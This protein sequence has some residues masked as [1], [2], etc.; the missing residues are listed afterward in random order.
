MEELFDPNTLLFFDED[1]EEEKAA[2][3]KSARERGDDQNDDDDDD[4]T[5]G[6]RGA[7]QRPVVAVGVTDILKLHPQTADDLQANMCA[8]HQILALIDTKMT[9]EK[10]EKLGKDVDFQHATLFMRSL[11]M[12]PLYKRRQMTLQ[13]I[14]RS[15][16]DKGLKNVIGDKKITC[17]NGQRFRLITLVCLRIDTDT[18]VV[19][20]ILLQ[21]PEPSP[22]AQQQQGAVAAATGPPV[23][24]SA[25]AAEEEIIKS[26]DSTPND[27]VF[28]LHILRNF[29]FDIQIVSID[30]EN[31]TLIY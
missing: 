9:P 10:R 14:V 16:M 15:V 2:K 6:G 7:A 29:Y 23:E 13:F 8:S 3:E 1:G 19:G 31:A 22:P 27:G 11:L 28:K 18:C 17:T 12:L 21:D 5:N 26:T 24:K 20:K 4:T 30:E 25:A